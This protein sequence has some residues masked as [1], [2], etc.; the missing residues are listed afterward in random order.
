MRRS[1][2][3]VDSESSSEGPLETDSDPTLYR[4]SEP[5]APIRGRYTPA[6]T[7]RGI[8]SV[9]TDTATLG[10]SRTVLPSLNNFRPQSRQQSSQGSSGLT[11]ATDNPVIPPPPPGFVPYPGQDPA[12]R[13]NPFPTPRAPFQQSPF[14][15]APEPPPP[16][17]QHNRNRSSDE[18]QWG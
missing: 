12:H 3:P 7:H 18:S 15:P 14:H 8:P 2:H 1:P 4:Y 5:S 11:Y 13:Q 16:Q 6:P 10:S 9:T 17:T